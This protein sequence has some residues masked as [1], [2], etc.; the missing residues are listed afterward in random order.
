[1]AVSF[2][3]H[4][5]ICTCMCNLNRKSKWQTEA[6][7]VMILVLH[8]FSLS[9]RT[10]A[11][12]FRGWKISWISS[13]VNFRDKNSVIYTKFRD[14]IETLIFLWKIFPLFPTQSWNSWNFSTTKLMFLYGITIRFNFDISFIYKNEALK[15]KTLSQSQ[16]DSCYCLISSI[17]HAVTVKA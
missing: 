6:S 8:L 17:M 13:T 9:Y 2:S 10:V 12:N 5:V 14:S 3:K 7:Q 1:M 16:H 11:G 15:C 4:M